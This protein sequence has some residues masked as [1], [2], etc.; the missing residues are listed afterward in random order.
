M[1]IGYKIKKMRIAAGLTQSQLAGEQITRNMLSYIESGKAL[2]SLDTLSYLAS[3]LS[4][5][6]SFLVSN[7]NNLFFYEK[8]DKMEDIK[9]SFAEANYEK[10]ID[11]ISKL[12]GED[13]EI[14]YILSISYF[15]LGKT[16]I[17]RGSLKSG[18]MMLEKSVV[19]SSK[20]IYDTSLVTALIGLY[21][22]LAENIQS[23]LLELN[24]DAVIKSI[25][26]LGELDLYNYIIQNSEYDYENR[27]FA[28]HLE[29]K[30]LIKLR[31]YI[32]ALS[33]LKEIETEKSST[34]YNA[35]FTLS[36]Y[37]DLE[38]CYRQIADYENAYR[39]ASKR[40]SLIEAFK[41]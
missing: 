40:I 1:N 35:Y 31:K 37:A 23:P 17:M 4:V 41:S 3:R 30:R 9:K 25:S 36:L 6:L 29:A 26:S 22:A 12:D 33:L 2:P 28:M 14:C 7:D 39:Y 10:C 5:P 11:L 34:G 13:D 8:K 21:G 15:N 27:M 20:T 24:Q 38:N 19:Y 18:K 16:A 32:D